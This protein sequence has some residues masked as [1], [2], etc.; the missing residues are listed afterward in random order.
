MGEHVIY[1]RRQ[2]RDNTDGTTSV[3]EAKVPGIT[4]K[5]TTGTRLMLVEGEQDA[6]ARSREKL[7]EKFLVEPVVQYDM[8]KSAASDRG[9]EP[10]Y[11]ASR[12]RP[13]PSYGAVPPRRFT[14][15]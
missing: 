3:S 2:F 12:L 7:G 8:L 14:Q 11:G 13:E 5:D 6:I 9:P 15:G 4:I 10:I 1:V